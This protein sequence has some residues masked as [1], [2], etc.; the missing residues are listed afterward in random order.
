MVED[1]FVEE[2]FAEITEQE[3]ETIRADARVV[4]ALKSKSSSVGSI[5]VGEVEIKFSL[6]INKRLR[7]KLAYYQANTRDRELA[8]PEV[9]A[10]MY[11]LLS[12]FC[13]EEPW[14]KP[15]TWEVY[16]ESAD[17]GAEEILVSIIQRINAHMEDV[18]NFR[19]VK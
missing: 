12:S 19:R 4:A 8:I 9:E 10:L 17:L 13:I 7:R 1:K 11:D 14:N 3:K 6:A 15:S 16:D 18:R 5:T 2:A